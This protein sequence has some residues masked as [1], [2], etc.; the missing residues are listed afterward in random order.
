MNTDEYFRGIKTG[1]LR[2]LYLFEGEEEYTKESALRELRKAVLSGAFACVNETTL[3]DPSEDELIAVAETLPMMAEKRLVVVRESALLAGSAA[4]GD[5]EKKPGYG[6]R[7]S[8]KAGDRIV[9]YLDR[10][11]ETTCLVFY[12]RGKA[13]PSRRLYKRIAASGGAVSF[14]PLNEEMLIKWIGRELKGY[15]KAVERRTVEQLIHVAG[16][17]MTKLKGELSKL[18]AYASDAPVIRMEDLE[19]VC[20]KTVEYRVFDLSDALAAGDAKRTVDLMNGMI[21]DG[22][23]RLA[24]LA[25]LQRQYR[26]LL[27]LKLLSGAGTSG[28]AIARTLGISS[29]IVGKLL[30]AIRKHSAEELHAACELCTDTEYLVKSGQMAE[31]GCLE[32]VVFGL[33]QRKTRDARRA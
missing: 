6:K 15:G 28:S 3:T 11:P 25:L 17:D 13:N 29:F 26:Q 24:L 22:E 27:F 12:V 32:Q 31:E 9:E 33:L 30:P 18:A 19:S 5:D 10:I 23:Q 20:A 21:R 14:D 1:E 16:S 8:G 7:S 2:P 4:G